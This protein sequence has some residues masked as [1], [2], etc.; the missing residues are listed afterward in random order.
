MKI[1]TI[2]NINYNFKI[3]TKINEDR[4]GND[5]YP[6]GII[7]KSIGY[8]YEH[9]GEPI[10]KNLT[11]IQQRPHE[12]YKHQTVSDFSAK[13]GKI[14]Q[15][16]IAAAAIPKKASQC[17][18]PPPLNDITLDHLN[19]YFILIMKLKQQ[20]KDR[21]QRVTSN[22]ELQSFVIKLQLFI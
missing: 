10:V 22:E 7:A 5:E 13:E 14:C 6:E 2:K 15:E 20:Q 4:L 17:H 12:F 1:Y 3:I 8:I 19:L 11:N 18:Q 16:I 21:T 9:Y